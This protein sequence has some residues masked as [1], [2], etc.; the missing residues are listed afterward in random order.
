[1]KKSS[2]TYKDS[3]VDIKAGEELVNSIKDLVKETHGVEVL[4]NIGGFGGYFKPQL[5][6]FKNPVF[7]SSVDGVGTKLI[8]AY[9]AKK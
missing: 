4:T 5:S 6:S 9:K 2:F 8:V 7:V 3:G 1:M